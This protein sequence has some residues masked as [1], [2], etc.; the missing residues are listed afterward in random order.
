MKAI[1]CGGLVPGC[2]YVARAESEDEVVA[3]AARHAK[4]VHGISVS[5]AVAAKV[6]RAVRDD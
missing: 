6:R 1:E 4:A 2:D 3:V 5:P